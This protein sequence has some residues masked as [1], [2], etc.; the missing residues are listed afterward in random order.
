VTGAP[1][2]PVDSGDLKR[3]QVLTFPAKWM[4]LSANPLEYAPDIEEG[5][6]LATGQKLTLRSLEGGFH[7]RKLTRAGMQRLTDDSVKE[8]LGEMP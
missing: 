5:R 8:I 7:S 2:L 3:H 1:G 6:R 4:F